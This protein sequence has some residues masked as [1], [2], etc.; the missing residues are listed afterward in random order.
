MSACPDGGLQPVGH[1]DFLVN[2]IEVRFYR[3]R[4]DVHFLGNFVVTESFGHEPESFF[5]TI[6]KQ[7]DGVIVVIGT[8]YAR[9]QYASRK[10]HVPPKDGSHS[11]EKNLPGIIFV[12]NTSHLMPTYQFLDAGI[13]IYVKKGSVKAIC[14]CR[15]AGLQ[16]FLQLCRFSHKTVQQKYSHSLRR[17]VDDFPNGQIGLAGAL[18]LEFFFE[19]EG[20]QSIL[21]KVRAHDVNVWEGCVGDVVQHVNQF[22][23]SFSWCCLNKTD[24]E[25]D[26]L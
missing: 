20:Q 16:A 13:R 12:K 22:L 10:P 25:P 6:R 1:P 26:N 23:A 3:V 9:G 8:Q 4:A 18:D 2:V 7:R 14:M 21:N 19:A 15:A 5:F 24:G 11:F 17:C